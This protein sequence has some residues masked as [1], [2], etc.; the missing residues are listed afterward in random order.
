VAV[1]WPAEGCCQNY[2]QAGLVLYGDDDNYLKLVA[3]SIWETRQTEFA[4]ER[5]PVP[6]GFPRYG[7]SVGGPVGPDWT[8]LRLSVR[9]GP[10]GEIVTAF[11]SR[12]GERWDQGATWMHDLGQVRIGLVAMGG[13][14]GHAARFDYVRTF[15][16]D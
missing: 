2:V 8:W 11:T 5:G 12:D 14:G 13:P 16:V 4:R 3:V 15:E 7:S 6:A 1:D 9:R 10:E